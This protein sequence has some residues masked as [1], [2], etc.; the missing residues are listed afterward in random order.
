[1]IKENKQV[2]KIFQQRKSEKQVSQEYQ[3]LF[4]SLE[5]GI[6]VVH[7][8]QIQFLNTIAIELLTKFGLESSPLGAIDWP[9]FRVYRKEED[10]DTFDNKS[11][12]MASSM[13]P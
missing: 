6:A 13:I 5:S 2:T 12:S 8:N 4:Q 10:M 3:E 1:M 11:V 7:N 9:L